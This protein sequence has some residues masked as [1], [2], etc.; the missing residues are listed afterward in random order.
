[1]RNLKK[2]VMEEKGF[3]PSSEIA[4]AVCTGCLCS[5]TKFGHTGGTHLS[6]Q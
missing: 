3:F 6:D 5:I 4:K 1:M 2:K